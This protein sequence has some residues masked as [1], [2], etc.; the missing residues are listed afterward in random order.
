M[1]RNRLYYG[2]KPMLPLRLRLA[3]RSWLARR[4]RA[5]VRDVWPILPGAEKTPPGF[6]GWPDGKKFALVL[7]HDVEGPRGL[8]NLPKVMELEQALGF[9]S[10]FNLIPEGDY[11]VT[12]RIRSSI[13]DAGFEVGVH[14]L[15]HDGKLYRSR[16]EFTAKASRINH[17]LQTWGA[18]G[19]RSG[20][21]LHNLDWLHELNVTYDASTFDTDPFEPQPQGQ[22]TIFPFWVPRPS[23]STIPPGPGRGGYVELPYTLPQD[24]TLFLILGERHPDIWFEKLA[25][26]AHHGGMVLLNV[27]PDYLA[28]DGDSSGLTYQVDNYLRL[29][30]YIT[31]KY[32][33]AFWNP[34]ARGL[35][36]FYYERVVRPELSQPA[37]LEWRGGVSARS[38]SGKNVAVVL[39]SGFPNDPRPRRE[40]EALAD[41][42]ATVDLICLREEKAAP[43]Q[44]TLG[45]LRVTRLPV[46]HQRSSKLLYFWNYARFFLHSFWLLSCRSLGRRYD[47]V[48]VHNMPDFLVFAALA[49]RLRGGKV[50]LDLHDPMPELYE[51]IYRLAPDSL[52]VKL[53]KRSEKLSIAFADLVLTPNEAFRRLF[54]SRSCDRA[55][56][57]IVMNTPDER[58]FDVAS[59]VVNTERVD[60][61]EFRLMFHGLIA[62]RHG[63]STAVRAIEKAAR[64]IPGLVMDVYGG[65]NAYLDEVSALAQNQGAAS[66]FRYCGKRKIDDI[67][68]AIRNCDLGVIPN[69]RTPFTEINFPTRIFEYLCLGK[70]VIVPRT[71]GI[72]DY[73]DE[74]SI[75]FFEPNDASD[76]AEKIIWTYS[77]PDEVQAIVNRGLQVY[78]EHRWTVE[79]RRFL[80]LVTT[81][82]DRGAWEANRSADVETPGAEV[83][84]SH[85]SKS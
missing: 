60:A 23:Q 52:M 33:G 53:L 9:R 62:E 46:E 64:S 73:F 18:T 16:Q 4:R 51:S 36:D 54:S 43:L 22:H 55:K 19:F 69:K 66:R 29:L 38:L 41:Q 14:D 78:L 24:S 81:L 34:T 32:G 26:I 68:A 75:I 17:Y 80:R 82:L 49:P 57:Q 70:P 27:H 7:T 21:M 65:R 3:V 5:T 63:L 35:A 45:S 44:E 6:P 2:I 50:I 28:F 58:L 74:K 20:F 59:P 79:R 56:V 67:P 48:H 85:A 77:N 13:Q 84:S 30:Q 83:E 12:E 37:G 1:L 8:R 76:L 25:W 10:S 72:Q 47:L 40:L 11:E 31:A 42:G 71:R 39:Y 15:H 61:K